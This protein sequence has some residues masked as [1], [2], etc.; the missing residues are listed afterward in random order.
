MR[1]SNA[2]CPSP[3]KR[4]KKAFK[5]N[6]QSE[7]SPGRQ[8]NLV[9]G[10]HS[11]SDRYS[12]VCSQRR[13]EPSF[14]ENVPRTRKMFKLDDTVLTSKHFDHPSD[15]AQERPGPKGEGTLASGVP[16]IH[17]TDL[18]HRLRSRAD[19]YAR[20]FLSLCHPFSLDDRPKQSQD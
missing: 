1:S 3:F 19:V 20:S 9:P 14:N 12:K 11:W 7:Q 13:S 8:L 15:A 2:G 4:P 10:R 6:S 17:Y 18:F 16:S 5:N